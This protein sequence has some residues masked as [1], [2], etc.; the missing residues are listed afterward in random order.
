V[1]RCLR[2]AA[3]MIGRMRRTSLPGPARSDRSRECERL[4]RAELCSKLTFWI[5]APRFPGVG[6]EP[7]EAMR[8]FRHALVRLGLFLQRLPEPARSDS[9]RV[10]CPRRD[11]PGASLG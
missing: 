11:P 4:W 9:L 7:Y 6:R 8:A 3:A 5:S 2:V 1:H 10:A